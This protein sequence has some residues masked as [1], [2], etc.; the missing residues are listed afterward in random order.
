MGL[1]GSCLGG[2]VFLWVLV[3]W[4]SFWRSL[5]YFLYTRVAPL[6]VFDI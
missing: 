1:F 6:Y 4:V 5:I 2:V 3:P